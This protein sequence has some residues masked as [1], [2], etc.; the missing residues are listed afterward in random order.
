MRLKNFLIVVDDLQKSARFYAD[1]FDLYVL[2]DHGTNIIL[3][4]GL[5]LQ[6]KRSWMMLTDMDPVRPNG[7]CEL[8]FE[9]EN[10]AEFERKAKSLGVD[11]ISE[12]CMQADGRKAV[13]LYDPD[14]HVIE[15]REILGA[16]IFN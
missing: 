4:G 11:F 12:V 5:V 16:S 8:Y 3:A 15:V 7:A 13:W 9:C 1:I 14:G 10:I 6:E 2:A